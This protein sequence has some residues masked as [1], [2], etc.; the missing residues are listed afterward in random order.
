MNFDVF[1]SI[2]GSGAPAILATAGVGIF[3]ATVL[4]RVGSSINAQ[5]QLLQDDSITTAIFVRSLLFMFVFI[6]FSIAFIQFIS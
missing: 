6:I 2:L 5:F 3:V 4:F 1:E